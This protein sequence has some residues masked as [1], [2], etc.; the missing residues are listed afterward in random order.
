MSRR[1]L[2][3]CFV[4]ILSA[5]TFAA[6]NGVAQTNPT[7]QSPD[8]KP[9]KV[10]KEP[11]TV[12]R[13]W[14]KEVEPI[15]TGPERE[16]YQKLQTDEERA[17][18]I[19]HFWFIRDP[20]PDTVE[21]EFKDEY[22]ERVTYSNERFTSG[23][24]GWLTD[25]GRIYI[26]WGKPDEIES[27][28]AGGQYERASYE[29][30]GSTSVYP[31]ERWFYRNIPGVGSGVEIEFVDPAGSGEYRMARN[32]DEK[33]ALLF[34]PGAGRTLDEILGTGSRADRTANV[35]GFGTTN[36]RRAQDS[37][38]EMMALATG[39][40]APPPIRSNGAGGGTSHTPV[41]DDS[42]LNLEVKSHYFFQSDGRVVTAFTIQTDNRDLVFQDSG[43]L[44]IA[45]LNIYGKVTTV[46]DRKVGAF[47][48]SVTTTATVTELAEAKER[49]SVYG[50]AVSLLPGVY[51]LD[52]VVRDLVSGATGVEHLGFTVPRLD[53]VKLTTSSI[54]L[55]AK[56]ESL[57]DQIGGGPFTIG[58]TKVVPN[59]SAIYHR[60]QPVGVYMQVYNAGTDQTTLRPAV[61]VEYALLKDGRELRKQAEDWTG[62]SEAGQRLTLARLIDTRDLAPGKYEIRIRIRDHVTNQELAPSTQFTVV[63]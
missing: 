54:V 5:L 23:K 59:I 39:L 31:F 24:P 56:L 58:L 10:K 14:P 26:K 48:D 32:P 37:P 18:F 43:G 42:T 4:M 44:Q 13:D 25:R 46:T 9:R 21:N 16:A 12:F 35:G 61:D 47:E 11:K 36:Y 63:P 52:V 19:E 40:M 1:S 55:A 7:A 62:M 34:A 29:G 53:P 38:F 33:D 49:K 60:G 30:G 2:V 8:Q 50:K 57:K 41:V 3:L 27:H 45:R 15:I 28:P 17:Q 22:Y 6:L 20:D 51:R